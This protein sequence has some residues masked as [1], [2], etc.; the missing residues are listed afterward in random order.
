MVCVSPRREGVEVD[1]KPE[2]MRA[3]SALVLRVLRGALYEHARSEYG[4]T[5][6]QLCDAFGFAPSTVHA[7]LA[8]L[9]ARRAEQLAIAER[10]A[11]AERH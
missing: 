10:F 11:Q 6:R 8:A 7:D 2:P 5:V 9:S 1:P 4:V 3:E